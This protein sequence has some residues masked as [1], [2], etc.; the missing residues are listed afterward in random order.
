MDIKTN[1]YFHKAL[2]KF[3]YSALKVINNCKLK[4]AKLKSPFTTNNKWAFLF[5][6]TDFKLQ[7]EFVVYFSE[8]QVSKK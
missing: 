6:S 2:I 8:K 7:A 4:A 3:T 1:R 5:Q